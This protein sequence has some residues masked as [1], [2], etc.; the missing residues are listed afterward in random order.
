MGSRAVKGGGAAIIRFDGAPRG[1]IHTGPMIVACQWNYR[2]VSRC[3]SLENMMFVG[4]TALPLQ[5]SLK[6]GKTG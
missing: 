4:K 3:L 2:H 5:P 6:V 1:R